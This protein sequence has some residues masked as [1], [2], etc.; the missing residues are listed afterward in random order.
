LFADSNSILGT[1]IAALGGAAVGVDRQRAYSENEPGAMGGLRTFTLLGTVAG[2]RGFLIANQFVSLGIVILASAA[3]MV[4]IVRLSAGRISRDATTEIAALAVLASGVIAGL[5]YL[6]TASALYAWT[7]LLLIEKSSL[8]AFV[9]RIG[10]IELE[11]AAQFAAMALVV[12]PLLPSRNFG[13][14]GILNLR[15]IWILVL[16]FS[17]ISF[18][19]YLAR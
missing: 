13:P 16:A 10:I 3:V 11:A 17:G 5:G 19:G 7:V 15:S 1:A 4:L 12:L 9:D 18:V 8:H 2:T 6:G 14:Q